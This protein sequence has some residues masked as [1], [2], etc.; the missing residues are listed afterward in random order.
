MVLNGVNAPGTKTSFTLDE[1]IP[2]GWSSSLLAEGRSM[3][4]VFAS[5]FVKLI[6]ADGLDS[7]SRVLRSTQVTKYEEKIL[8]AFAGV[9]SCPYLDSNGRQTRLRSR[10]V[11]VHI[12]AKSV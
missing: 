8:E 11:G 12:F 7:L 10:R 2:S 6:R 1:G 9:F 4:S 3:D 5:D